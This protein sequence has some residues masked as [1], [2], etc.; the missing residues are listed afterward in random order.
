MERLFQ[1][2]THQ[3]QRILNQEI[4]PLKKRTN[5]YALL[6][7]LKGQGTIYYDQD[8]LGVKHHDLLIVNLEKD[9]YYSSDDMVLSLVIC[10]GSLIQEVLPKESLFSLQNHHA[11]QQGIE[12]LIAQENADSFHKI[13][14]FIHLGSFLH[15][16]LN[17]YTIRQNQDPMQEATK[18]IQDHFNKNISVDIIAK[19]IGYSNYYFIR[20][21]KSY[22]GKTP[23]QYLLH[24]RLEHAKYL[25]KY[26]SKTLREIAYDSGFNSDISFINAFSKHLDI[27]PTTYRK[28]K[29]R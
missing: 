7:V 21:F 3:K 24:L 4:I 29:E 27:S 15:D 13:Q 25:L 11:F 19:K 16:P 18:Y 28:E 23:Y 12:E 20:K 17:T 9:A 14:A 2:L 5:A 1:V 8:F 6:Y 22:L 10:E 26:T